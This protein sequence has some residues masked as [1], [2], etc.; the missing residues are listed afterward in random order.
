MKKITLLAAAFIFA[1]GVQAQTTSFESSEGYSAGALDGQN[2][3]AIPVDLQG[4]AVAGTIAVD[5]GEA[6]DGTSA[7]KFNTGNLG[8]VEYAAAD[9]VGAGNTIDISFD[10]YVSSTVT[11][12]DDD[13]VRVNLGSDIGAGVYLD[14]SEGGLQL[15]NVG[16]DQ[17]TQQQ[18]LY[19]LSDTYDTPEDQWFTVNLAVDIDQST[20]TVL[21][22]GDTVGTAVFG[23]II[24]AGGSIANIIPA[25]KAAGLNFVTF[26][27]REAYVDNTSYTVTL[28]VEDFQQ[29]AAFTHYVQNNH[30]YLESKTEISQVAVY[31]MLGQEVANSEIN[32][33]NGSLDLSNLTT[34]VYLGKAAVNGQAKSF[35]FVIK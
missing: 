19:I 11:S 13:A 23:G 17:A 31:N 30:L 8:Y 14:F 7:V 18:G 4:Q 9:S 33:T 5:N 12:T 26:G 20:A 6:S 29:Q 28:G 16:I 22:A 27:G 35:K 34:G 15:L 21:V 2:G 32:N 1:A 25:T 10:A 3:W 24:V